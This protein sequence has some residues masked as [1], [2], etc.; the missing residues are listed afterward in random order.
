MTT[1]ARDFKESMANLIARRPFESPDANPVFD[2]LA[3]T[4][5][6]L[7][8]S[9]QRTSTAY[10]KTATVKAGEDIRPALEALRSAGGGTL[11]LLAGVHK[12]TYD[13]VGGSKIN[14]VGEGIDQT[15]IDFQNTSFNIYYNNTLLSL[16]KDF[17]IKG[18]TI[19]NSIKSDA[20]LS[21]FYCS[22]FSLDS[23][24]VINCS[25]EGILFTSCRNFIVSN[26]LTELNIKSGFHIFT[27]T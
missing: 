27:S 23:V 25:G 9:I 2:T 4:N 14:I 5:S 10:G 17:T 12:P 13:I 21:F 8:G 3:P 19:Q 22:N 6:V 1:V 26:C 15:I 7:Q 11:I 24:K 18:F 20:G 16:V